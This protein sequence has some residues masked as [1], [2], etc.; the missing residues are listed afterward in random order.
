MIQA[1]P[2]SYQRQRHTLVNKPT[3]L[4][5]QLGELLFKKLHLPQAALEQFL[6][7]VKGPG[8]EVRPASILLSN[9]N[10]SNS[11]SSSLAHL[12]SN[13]RL[14]VF[15]GGYPSDTVTNLVESAASP[16]ATA[17]FNRHSQIFNVPAGPLSSSSSSSAI[18]ATAA[19]GTAP[20]SPASFYNSRYKKFEF[21][22][23]L[24]HRSSI[25]MEQIQKAIAEAASS[26]TAVSA[27]AEAEGANGSSA[28]ST[29]KSTKS[30]RRTSEPVSTSAA[31]S[32]VA[33]AV[34]ATPSYQ[35]WSLTSS[36]LPNIL[37]DAQR[38]RGSQQLVTGSQVSLKATL[39]GK[40]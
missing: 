16:L 31:S 27:T 29:M 28:S 19:S 10:S 33:A 40:P 14:S 6:W 35:G 26:A 32:A 23:V 11:S 9:S 24:R 18:S 12:N 37:S 22:Q 13:P 30:S 38:R 39:S 1:L 36:A 34:Q 7:V 4:L 25:S 20:P 3:L 21:S 2:L 5:L 15:G 8:K 17:A